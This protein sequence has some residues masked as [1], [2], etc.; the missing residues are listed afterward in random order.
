MVSAS[1]GQPPPIVLTHPTMFVKHGCVYAVMFT[2]FCSLSWS[3]MGVA[4]TVVRSPLAL[5]GKQPHT[6]LRRVRARRC[7]SIVSIA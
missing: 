2:I 3:S 5:A 1:A 6:Q 7:G 4:S